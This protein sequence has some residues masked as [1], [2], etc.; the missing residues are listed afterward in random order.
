MHCAGGRE[1]SRPYVSLFRLILPRSMG[2]GSLAPECR[3]R[4]FQPIFS[5]MHD[6]CLRANGHREWQCPQ[7]STR[8]H[9]HGERQDDLLRARGTFP[10]SGAAKKMRRRKAATGRRPTGGLRPWLRHKTPRRLGTG[11]KQRHKAAN[12]VRPR[13]RRAEIRPPQD[14]LRPSGVGIARFSVG[15]PVSGIFRG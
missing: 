5:G 4:Q 11:G 10:A 12:R 1:I 2:K 6:A 7:L 8:R 14:P 15:R 13:R 3:A 9:A